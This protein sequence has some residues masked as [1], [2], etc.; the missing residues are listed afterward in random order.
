MERA[1]FRR[2]VYDKLLKW[3][4]EY[5]GR[6]ACLLE[7]AR[8]V[9]KST[10]AENFAK[11]EYDSYIRIDFANITE[12]LLD[13]FRDI[14]KPD[15]FFLRLQAETGIT[16][17]KRK[18]VI[19]FDEIQLNPKVR[20]AIK[21]LVQDGRYDYIETGSLISIRK[22]VQDIVIPSEEHRIKVYPMD[23]EE[24]SWA[25]GKDSDT[26]RQLFKAGIQAGNALNRSLMRDFRIYMAV[27]GMPQAVDAYIKSNNFD[28]VDSVKKEI[29]DLYFD[30]LMKLDPTGRLSAVYSS[31][32]S[33][34]ALKKKRFVVS[35]ATG[36]QKTERDDERIFELI[37]SGMVIPCWHVKNPGA[38]LAL[39]RE[40]DRFKLYLA[41]TG[42]FVTMMI[43]KDPEKSGDIYKK[44]LGDKL[45]ADLGYLY[46]NIAAQI[47]ASKGT[48]LYYHTWQKGNSTHSFEIDFLL[49][50]GSKIIPIEVKSSE[51]KN[52]ESID[53]FAEKYQQYISKRYLFSQKDVCNDKDLQLKPVYM[54]P[55]AAEDFS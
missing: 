23:F 33:Q 16:L 9:G 26:L 6:Y 44:F 14:A 54:L 28:H 17:K 4:Q 12:E 45:P 22:N 52:H 51:T 53:R 27:G 21:Y 40:I 30:D 25:T 3:K 24:F 31:V 47:L 36:K 18:S 55:F 48:D 46:E 13:V 8:R 7:G 37:N 50:R 15:I 43:A 35:A 2:K 49:S 5:N 32:P 29:I 42:L 34:L 1:M 20:Q 11:N 10:I 39:T 38:T 19:I 41:D